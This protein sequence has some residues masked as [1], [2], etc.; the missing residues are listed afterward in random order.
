MLTDEENEWVTQIESAAEGRIKDWF[1]VRV[2]VKTTADPVFIKKDWKELKELGPEK[3]LI[4]T[5]ISADNVERWKLNE[6]QRLELLYTHYD[7]GGKKAVIDLDKFPKAANYLETHRERLEGRG[8]VIKA[9]RKWFEIWVP[10]NPR[11]WKY[12]KL[13]FPDISVESKFYLDTSGSIVNGNCYWIAAENKESEQR[14]KLIQGVANSSLMSTYH[15]LMFNNKLYSGRR[16]YF[17]QY[18]EKYPVPRID[19]DASKKII[20]LVEKLNS[21]GADMNF[22]KEKLD[23]LVIEA[24]SL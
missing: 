18:V 5:L 23:T 17:S 3:D 15:D 14:L 6:D 8:Y 20:K 19:C 1:K 16:R 10:Q 22:E 2:G 21:K 9:K 4:H 13:V 12:P 7:N 24:F 11:A